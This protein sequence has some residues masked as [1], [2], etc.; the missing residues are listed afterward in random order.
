MSYHWTLGFRSRRCWRDGRGHPKGDFHA[1]SLQPSRGRCPGRRREPVRLT[2]GVGLRFLSRSEPVSRPQP[3]PLCH[4]AG[5]LHALPHVLQ[6]VRG[7]VAYE[8]LSS[9]LPEYPLLHPFLAR[10]WV[11]PL[12]RRRVGRANPSKGVRKG[13]ERKGRGATRSAAGVE[14]AP[15]R[16]DEPGEGMWAPRP[17]SGGILPCGRRFGG[18]STGLRGKFQ[19]SMSNSQQRFKSQGRSSSHPGQLL[20]GSAVGP[21]L[22][23]AY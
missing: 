1:V 7:S 18:A 17:M 13:M 12:G 5:E 22:I 2:G 15:S 23:L 4:V 21:S 11:L 8:R 10:S 14:R 9:G 3:R 19:G 20:W 6:L 16:M